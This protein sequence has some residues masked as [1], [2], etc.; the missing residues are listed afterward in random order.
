YVP[1]IECPHAQNTPPVYNTLCLCSTGGVWRCV[2]R[3]SVIV[4]STGVL[5]VELTPLLIWGRVSIFL[6][7]IVGWV[8][9][10]WSRR[11][12]YSCWTAGIYYPSPSHSP[13]QLILLDL[14]LLY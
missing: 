8:P 2:R 3:L 9:C 4:G 7:F 10:K 6:P 1:I 11:C 13:L 5:V 14:I 12:N